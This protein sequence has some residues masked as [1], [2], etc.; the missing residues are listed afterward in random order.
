LGCCKAENGIVG[1][2]LSPRGWP[3]GLAE[4]MLMGLRPALGGHGW[5]LRR[6]S[7]RVRLALACWSVFVLAGVPLLAVT[8]GLWLGTTSASGSSSGSA[9]APGQGPVPGAGTGPAGPG[10]SGGRISMS[11]AT[12]SFDLHQ[13]LIVSALAL[14]LMAVPA[15]LIGWVVAGR[16]VRPLQAMT[17]AARNISATNLH[18][19]L[20]VSGPDDELKQL[21]DTFDGLLGRLERSFQS[22]RQFVANA[23]HELRTPHATMRVW[24]EVALGK[25]VPA[26][27]HMVD[28]GDRLRHELDHVDRLLDGLLVLA[29]AQ[30][31][32]AA[33]TST[34]ALDAVIGAATAERAGLI[35][36]LGLDVRHQECA[37]ALVTGS[38]T[39]LARMV[40][41]VVDN[42]VTHNAPGGWVRIRTETAGPAAR[43]VIENGGPVLDEGD[44]Q[45]LAQPFRRLGAERTGSDRGSGLGLSIVAA[46]A[47]M[48]DGRLELH[49][50]AGG[51]F[52]VVIELPLALRAVVPA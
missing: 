23:S 52:Q 46:I 25:P 24:L 17:M 22:Q 43:L 18:E 4:G 12:H 47:E 7:L 21:G 41:N 3:G 31:H 29:R 15:I 19:R 40:G 2:S 26:P 48:H 50:L 34:L 8:V 13:L 5:P 30:Q 27:P 11:A 16:L 35:A 37:A 42:A 20:N 45:A 1:Q 9:A 36:G 33:D 6:R 38:E 44:V 32:S 39:L 10:G 28:L 14:L 51:G 49:A